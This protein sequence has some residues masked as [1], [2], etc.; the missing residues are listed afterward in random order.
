MKTRLFI[1]GALMLALAGCGGV[2]ESRLNPLNW[3]NNTTEEAVV[4]RAEAGMPLVAQLLSL[5]VE[6][7]TSGAVL[8][9]LGLPPTQGY[10]DAELVAL[11]DMRPIDGTLRFE[12]RATPPLRA[13]R[14]GTQ[15]SRELLVGRELPAT[16]LIGVRRIEV[17]A[18]TNR[19]T[20]SR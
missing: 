9:A 7:T 8:Y 4:T 17:S 12:F 19:L 3:F 6:P 15:Q 1:S 11:N 5:Q 10:Y 18:A 20:I 16:A 2:G 14:A 13:A